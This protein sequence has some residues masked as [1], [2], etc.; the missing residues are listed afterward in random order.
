MLYRQN[1][2]QGALLILASELMFA[3]MGAAVKG[4]SANLPAEVLVFMRNAVGW[5]VVL[6]N[7]WRATT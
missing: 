2:V 3:T 4:A 7:V 5:L 1:I 6:P